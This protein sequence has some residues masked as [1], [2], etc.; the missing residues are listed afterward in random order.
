MTEPTAGV[1]RITIPYAVSGFN[2]ECRMYVSNPTLSGGTWVIDFHPDV[3]GTSNWAS[4]AQGLADA[5]SWNLGTGTTPG[6]VLLEEYSATGWLPRDTTTVTLT[7]LASSPQLASQATLT[8]R[9]L[10]FTRPKI[11]VM[12]G[13]FTP[14]AKINSPTGGG[15]NQDAWIDGFLGTSSTSGRPWA[16]MTTMHGIFLLEESFV[17][18]TATFNRKL[19]RARGLA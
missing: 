4:A 19:R 18:A 14:P 16:F 10:D 12:E 17:S 1:G 5:I 15:G 13:N 11:V 3:G 6:T 9:A 2:H 7:N 8:L